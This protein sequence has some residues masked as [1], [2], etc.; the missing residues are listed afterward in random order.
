MSITNEIKQSFKHGSILTRLIYINLAVFVA[1]RIVQLFFFLSNR[2]FTLLEWLALPDNP[3]EFLTKPWTIFTYM[4]LH[5]NFIHILFNLLGLYWFGKMFL[6]RFDG[7]KLLG[8]YI[9]G[10]IMG[11]ALYMVSYN[12]F[13]VFENADGLLLG[14]SASIFAILVALAVYEPNQEIYLAFVGAVKMKWVAVFYLALS[15]I[16]I[17]AS[18]PGG[19]IAH[20]GGALWGYLYIVQLR[21]GRDMASWLNYLLNKLALVFKPR[22]RIRVT[23]KQPPRD[24]YEYNRQKNQN[25][26]EINRILEK[27]SKS[28]YQALSKEEKETLFKQG[29]R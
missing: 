9:L 8:L 24:D 21:K 13:P 28:G 23:Y 6:Y 18:N 1:V 7:E 5:Y 29:K 20:L 17:S 25:Q 14:A 2:E 19:N 11:G 27:I 16:G 22:K 10:G 15:A 12:L 3:Q 4:F 26:D